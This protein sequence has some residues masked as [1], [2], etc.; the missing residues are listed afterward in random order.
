MFKKLNYL[1]TLINKT[2]KKI[3]KIV[4]LKKEDLCILFYILLKNIVET[5]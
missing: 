3:S 2:I 1:Q 4:L 5:Y